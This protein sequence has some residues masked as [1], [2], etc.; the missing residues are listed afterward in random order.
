[1]N[2]GR[3]KS[4][5]T[6]GSRVEI[7]FE[8]AVGY[9]TAVTEDII[10]VFS[11]FK[12]ECNHSFA[13]EGDKSKNVRVIANMVGNYMVISTSKL[14]V[15]VY[16]NFLIRFMKSDGTLICRD[17]KGE[18]EAQGAAIISQEA[19]EQARMEGHAVSDGISRHKI[20]VI[21]CAEGDEYFYGLGDKYNF[22]NKK[23]YAFEMWNSDIP[24]PHYESMRS[25]Y[26]SMPFMIVHREKVD[27]GIFFDNHHRTQFD[28][29]KENAGYYSFSAD[30]G[31][32]NYYLIS[33]DSI[34]SVVSGYTY[35]TGTTPLPQLWTLG[36]QQCRWSY[37]NCDELMAVAKNMRKNEIPCDVLYCDID[38]MDNFKVFTWG[39]KQYPQH[40]EMIDTLKKHGFKVVTIIDPGV[41]KEK[42]YSI[43]DEGV[44]N[45][46]FVHDK[47]GSIY[48]NVVWPGD[49]VFP[50]FGRRSVRNWWAD[51]QRIMT[52]DG[53]AGIWNDMNEP[54]SFRGE[55]PGD[56]V[57]CDEERKT[58]HSEMHNVYGSLM[59]KATYE[60]IKRHTG[61]RPF[62]ITRACYSGAQKYTTGWTGDN[63][64]HWSHL[65][66]SIAQICSVGLCGMAFI[67]SDVGGFGSDCTPELLCRWTQLGCFT[68]FFRNHAAKGTRYQE[69]WAFDRQTLDI[70]RKYIRLRYR[71]IPYIYDCFHETE[72][73]GLPVFRPLCL[74]FQKDRNA[75]EVNDQFMV[76]QWLMVAPIVDQGKV[77]RDVYLPKGCNWYDFHTG[78]KFPGG[79]RILREAPLDTC[80]IYV[81][82][83]AVL[84]M[85]Q[86]MNYVG[87]K[88]VDC[89]ELV[90][91]GGD[92]EY[93]H[94]QDNGTDFAYREGE[95]N[96]YRFVSRRGCLSI[97]QINSGY[98]ERYERFRINL[99]G[100]LFNIKFTG[101]RIN[102]IR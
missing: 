49:S 23:G 78:E 84:P 65:R 29:C 83:G 70:C 68:P 11:P 34:K 95:Y 24:D 4:F 92:G 33:G 31:D 10:N 40:K 1:M 97:E 57:F 98:A 18:R 89:L 60:G 88:K 79:T 3:I 39:E 55:I 28:L 25:L 94:Y 50:D 76:G 15:Y 73:T 45:D 5:N 74:E 61:R 46:F 16:D 91:Y 38:Y 35:L 52:D 37:E 22:L 32:L 41:K 58:T 44:K 9:I 2:F 64:S 69:P 17:Y 81:R 67:G 59:S 47:D 27:Y 87:E 100:K 72:S 21:K 66:Y 102:A 77:S 12:P 56:V 86:V 42:G 13:I 71:L 62:V 19:M 85:W 90:V 8:N 53:V 43:Y 6:E 54:A 7:N 101:G 20:E 36:Y 30:D 82:E 93:L 75:L 51:N 99:S 96:I 48:E 26:K 63:Q 80:P 14:A